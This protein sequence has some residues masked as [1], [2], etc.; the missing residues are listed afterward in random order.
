MEKEKTILRLKPNEC[1][2]FIETVLENGNKINVSSAAIEK[3]DADINGENGLL[4]KIRDAEKNATE[5]SEAIQD[6]YSVI[7]GDENSEEMWIKEKL[8]EMVEDFRA[9]EKEIN[10]FEKKIFGDEEKNESTWELVKKEWLSDKIDQFFKQGKKEYSDLMDDIRK[11][12]SPW[13]TSAQLAGIFRAKVEEYERIA[14]LWSFGFI[15][16][17][18]WTM[19][20]YANVIVSN[21]SA[22]TYEGVWIQ[23]LY[24]APFLIFVIW[25]AMFFWNRR[26]ESKKL[27]EAYKHKEVMASSYTGYRDAIEELEEDDRELLVN[28]MNNLL[29]AIKKDSSEFLNS[30]WEHYPIMWLWNKVLFNPQAD[31]QTDKDKSKN[32]KAE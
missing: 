32:S 8:D 28:H 7:I 25:L 2:Q 9:S 22:T 3:A 11:R 21:T 17:V 16:I 14:L 29:D 5:K 27:A 23:V 15:A 13:A 31:Q 26:A 18:G 30:K 4:K 20:W 24:R 12:L 19:A 10:E 1:R 6:A